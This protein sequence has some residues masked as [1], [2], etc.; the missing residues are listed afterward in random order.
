MR[1]RRLFWVAILAALVAHL[2]PV[3]AG[4]YTRRTLL[5]GQ[6][7]PEAIE[8]KKDDGAARK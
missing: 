2:V 8:A 6:Q 7:F 3:S 4:G 1:R 5:L